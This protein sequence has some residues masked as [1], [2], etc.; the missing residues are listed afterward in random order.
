M[1][2]TV[3]NQVLLN[4]LLLVYLVAAAVVSPASANTVVAAGPWQ[5]KFAEDGVVVAQREV[6]G[7][8]LK[9]TRGELVMNTHT[10]A[11][12]AVLKDASACP[13]W[14][15]DCK[16]AEEVKTLNARERI[17]YSVVD[18]P[19]W[20]DDRD[21]YVHSYITM[22][23]DTGVVDV[24][25]SGKPDYAALVDERVRVL[26]LEA[27]WRFEP[28]G[29]EQVRVIYSVFNNPQIKAAKAVNKSMVE[30]VASTLK[31]LKKIVAQPD[32]AQA[33]FSAELREA[34]SE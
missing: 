26:D 9:Q 14:I 3:I 21:L 34:I 8:R 15:F 22:Q 11:L 31:G 2:L 25:L 6:A 4:P 24:K 5:T 16:F 27:S 12:V 23:R 19:L 29:N 10:S 1:R 7:S 18:A 32:Y 20:F 17:S 33:S 30:A 28:L 13:Q